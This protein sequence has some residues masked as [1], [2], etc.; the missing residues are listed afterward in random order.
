MDR[1]VLRA[2]RVIRA[3][4][5]TKESQEQ[6]VCKEFRDLQTVLKAHRVSWVL[7]FKVF[8]VQP[9]FRV[10]QVLPTT[11]VQQVERVQQVQWQRAHKV[12]QD[13]HRIQEPR[14]P[15]GLLARVRQAHRVLQAFKVHPTD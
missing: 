6:L 1:R 11:R 13:L 14:D 7:V 3:Q 5:E 2:F 9:D 4:W 12:L 8:R 10:L 15:Q